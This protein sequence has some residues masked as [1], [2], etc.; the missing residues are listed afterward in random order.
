MTKQLFFLGCHYL[1]ISF[2]YLNRIKLY[3]LPCFQ[4]DELMRTVLVIQFLL[5]IRVMYVEEN[6]FVFV[7]LSFLS[8][9]LG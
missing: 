1:F 5:M 4:V 7:I 2:L 6:D 3:H 8:R 9:L